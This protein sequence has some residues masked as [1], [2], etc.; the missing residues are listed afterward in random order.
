MKIKPFRKRK[1]SISFKSL[2]LIIIP[3]IALCFLIMYFS[4]SYTIKIYNF[5][6]PILYAFFIIL[7]LFLFFLVRSLFKSKKHGFLIAIFFIIYL[8]FRINSLTHPLFLF[9]LI[10]L[11]LTLELFFTKYDEK[12]RRKIQ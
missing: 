9:L 3:F 7:F 8:L 4:P 1:I 12:K 10:A 11:F 2:F 5:Q 6:I